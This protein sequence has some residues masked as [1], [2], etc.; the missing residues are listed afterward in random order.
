[1]RN[2]I[3]EF[4]TTTSPSAN[5][6]FFFGSAVGYVLGAFTNESVS[7]YQ[8]N[9]ITYE[10]W[11][12]NNSYNFGSSY[13][14]I[15][16]VC[17]GASFLNNPTTALIL[18]NSDNNYTVVFNRIFSS[19]TLKSNYIR[20]YSTIG[21]NDAY[22][23]ENL[24]LLN[25]DNTMNIAYLSIPQT[26]LLSL[27]HR[28]DNNSQVIINDAA[29]Q[30][31]INAVV[32]EKVQSAFNYMDPTVYNGVDSISKSNG[33]V[34][35]AYPSIP[36]DSLI[37]LISGNGQYVIDDTLIRSQLDTL[38]S[39]KIDSGVVQLTNYYD[40]TYINNLNN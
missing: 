40:K 7:I 11:I 17:S 12:Q 6:P 30:T 4:R 8:V 25:S 9:P 38:A 21:S 14:S 15:S 39:G 3:I 26:S 27:S 13:F 18:S 31:R 10:I 19:D 24:L 37:R 16:G 35:V 36:K 2:L 20:R 34:T 33:V 22:F 32:S 23:N 28:P 5:K 29:I 1:M